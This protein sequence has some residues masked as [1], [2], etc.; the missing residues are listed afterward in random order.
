[1]ALIPLEE[2]CGWADGTTMKRDHF[3]GRDTLFKTTTTALLKGQCPLCTTIW[4][5]EKL[6]L[7]SERYKRTSRV[8]VLHLTQQT[9]LQCTPTTNKTLAGSKERWYLVLLN[10]SHFIAA[11][12]HS[13]EFSLPIPNPIRQPFGAGLLYSKRMLP[14]KNS[15]LVAH[16]WSLSSIRNIKHIS[17]IQQSI[18]LLCQKSKWSQDWH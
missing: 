1:M 12:A 2:S 15:L 17:M 4:D 3:G 9:L 8:H 7:L 18:S 6:P 5:L 10:S 11:P 16:L 13:W 14:S